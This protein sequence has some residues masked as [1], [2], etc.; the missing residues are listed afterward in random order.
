MG[1]TVQYDMSYSDI[2]NNLILQV[3]LVATIAMLLLIS[4]EPRM[5]LIPPPLLRWF[6]GA[7]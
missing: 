3:F 7:A 4:V 6:T 1:G 5:S 2:V